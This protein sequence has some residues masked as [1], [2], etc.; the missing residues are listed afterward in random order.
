MLFDTHGATIAIIGMGRVGTGAYDKMR[1]LYGETVVGVD[2]DP[3]T[4]KELR[5]TGRKV[6]F[7]DPSDADFWD[8]VAE[9]H[10][11]QLVMLALP[12]LTTNLSVLD[13]LEAARFAGRVAATARF[14]DE[15]ETLKQAGA[16]T[17][18][19]IYTEAGTGFAAHVAAETPD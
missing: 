15:V 8:R 6:L 11:I 5:S 18:F 4:V 13:Q 10:T 9:T 14:P 2:F 16:A 17:V 1:S 19:N 7:G 12:K 3:V